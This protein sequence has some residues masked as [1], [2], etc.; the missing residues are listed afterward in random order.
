M[1]YRLRD[2]AAG[3]EVFGA[4]AEGTTHS[5]V[6]E[7]LAQHDKDG[8]PY[9]DIWG[10]TTG[11]TLRLITYAGTYDCAAGANRQNLIVYAT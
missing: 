1:F 6:V 3:D 5:F 11:P 4:D 8:L 10:R 2:L 9:G 7:R